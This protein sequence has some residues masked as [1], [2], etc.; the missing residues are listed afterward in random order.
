MGFLSKV[1]RANYRMARDLG[2]L[3]AVTKG[4]GAVGRRVVRR[5]AYKATNRLLAKS[6]RGLFK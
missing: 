3:Q 4:P 5:Q 2:D 6:L 1:R